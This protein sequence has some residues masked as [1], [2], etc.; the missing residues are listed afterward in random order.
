MK[1]RVILFLD[2]DGVICDSATESFVTSWAAYREGVRGEPPSPPPEEARRD[3]FLMRPLSRR[4]EDFMLM[5]DL[6][7]RGIVL[8][9]QE[10]FDA[11]ARRAGADTMRRYRETI[12]ATRAKVVERDR[13]AW[14]KLNRIYP[15][16][17]E[18]FRRMP[19]DAPVRI[20]STK[21]PEYVAEIL[22]AFSLPVDRSRVI[23]AEN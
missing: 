1:G 12:Y 11:E 8:R 19:A 16:M 15:H 4:G 17:E 23:Y 21:R 10:S 2:F 22:R 14:L 20:I 3:F 5:Q 18:A 9:D 6:I 13:S 7:R